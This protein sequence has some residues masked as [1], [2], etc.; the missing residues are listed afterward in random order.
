[1]ALTV[2][3]FKVSHLNLSKNSSQV[4]LNTNDSESV[5]DAPTVRL[6]VDDNTTLLSA[7]TIFRGKKILVIMR[8]FLLNADI[9]N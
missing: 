3:L 7:K 1:M 4:S 2:F 8:Q 9:F 5:M 6:I